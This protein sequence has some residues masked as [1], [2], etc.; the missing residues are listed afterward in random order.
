MDKY[1]RLIEVMEKQNK[2][3]DSIWV[4]LFVITV[5]SIPISICACWAI[6]NYVRYIQ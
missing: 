1:D 4:L 5:L 2:I 3:A 6:L